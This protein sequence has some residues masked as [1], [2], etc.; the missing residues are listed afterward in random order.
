VRVRLFTIA[1]LL[2]LC[3]FPARAQ[4]VTLFTEMDYLFEDQRFRDPDHR[5]TTSGFLPR[6]NLSL[7]GRVH[8]DSHLYLDFAGGLAEDTFSLSHQRTNDMHL[9]LRQDEPRYRA[10]L[11]FGSSGIASSTGSLDLNA[12]QL[13][14]NTKTAGV[15]LVL[16][17]PAWPVLNL[18]YARY[19]SDTGLGGANAHSEAADSRV[20]AT[21]DL[22]PLRFQFDDSRRTGGS[23]GSNRF[24]L[25]TRRFNV[26][27]DTALLPKLSLFGDVQLAHSDTRSG[28]AAATGNDYRI[29]SLRLSTELTPKVA[30]DAQTYSQFT[31][32]FPQTGSQ[33]FS[34]RGSSLAMRSEVLPGLQLDL[35]RNAIRSAFAGRETDATSTE[36]DLL[37]GIS[38]RNSLAISFMPSH[39]IFS[40]APAVAQ[41]AYR[42]SWT[43]QLDSQADFIASLER[44]TNS[45]IDF[46]SRT[47]TKYAAWRYRPDLQTTLGLGLE[48]NTVSTTGS[49]GPTAQ[50]ARSLNADFSW[51]PTSDLTLGVHLSITR[52]TGTS[53][54]RA[55]L[56]GFDI[57]WQP[58][59]RSEFL[60]S[61][62]LQSAVQRELDTV[63]RLGFDAL[64]AHFSRRLSRSSNLVVTYNVLKFSDGPF[65]YDRRLGVSIT[66]GLGR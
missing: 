61:W 63:T 50:D 51:L 11:R 66:T 45:G 33:D 29:G 5:I 59:S 20:A 49:A 65:A 40:D 6:V 16:R 34:S 3:P 1:I 47:A 31:S 19:T 41:H 38:G 44:F 35:S 46:G 32:F 13:T 43:S 18:Q 24:E 10:S 62:R 42:V 9:V 22:T 28:A 37:A 12:S 54:T 56:P 17:E 58:D 57:R 53:S 30:V 26:S 15:T 25:N 55:K 36:A 8:P 14:A 64:S 39:A 48:W 4:H 60:L 52:Q 7:T 2:L 27:L 23:P 21:Y